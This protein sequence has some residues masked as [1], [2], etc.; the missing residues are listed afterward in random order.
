MKQRRA[1]VL[2]GFVLLGMW[3]LLNSRLTPAQLL[4]GA[5]LAVGM[6]ALA[7]RLRPVRPRLY[8]PLLVLPLLAS[9]LVDGVR[10]NVGVARIVLGL[11]GSREVHS[12]FLTIPIELRDPHALAMLAAIITATPGTA[13]AGLSSDGTRLTLHLLD[14]RNEAEWTAMIKQRYETPLRRIFEP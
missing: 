5:A 3:L 4:L 13:W 12:G 11:T 9:V 14:L 6:L 10:S 1:P 8:R 7:A 2:L